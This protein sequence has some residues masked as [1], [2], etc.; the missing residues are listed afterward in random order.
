MTGDISPILAKKVEGTLEEIP[1]ADSLKRIPISP[2]LESS[3]I[4]D[5]TK[6][7]EF[8]PFRH[9]FKAFGEETMSKAK[10]TEP[11]SFLKTND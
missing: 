2:A 11:G 10:H 3:G 7:S 6:M 1:E 5:S 9:G 4:L 8:D